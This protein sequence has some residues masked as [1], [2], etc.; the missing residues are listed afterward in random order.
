MGSR[1]IIL[2]GLVLAAVFAAP[3][4]LAAEGGPIVGIPIGLEGDPGS[5]RVP[6]VTDARGEALFDKLEP[7]RYSVVLSDISILKGPIRISIGTPDGVM[8][9]SEPIG[10]GKGRA[11]AVDKSG[12]RLSVA[13]PRGVQGGGRA[14]G[15]LR[16]KLTI[17][18]RWGRR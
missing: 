14:G 18:D 11:Y 13:I 9:T 15:Q 6:G 7:A 16:V 8:L 10:P 12:R 2:A 3:L 17:F 1:R 5:V 4:A